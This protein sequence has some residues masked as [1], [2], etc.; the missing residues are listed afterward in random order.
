MHDQH[1]LDLSGSVK[2]GVE[3]AGLTGFRFNTIGVSDG[4]SMGTD[5]MRR[6]PTQIFPSYYMIC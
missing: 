1:L 3:A 6:L 4:I 5:G 2:I